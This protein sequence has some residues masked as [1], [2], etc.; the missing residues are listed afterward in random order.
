MTADSSD[1]GTGL[2]D[3]DVPDKPD[4][5]KLPGID[6]G[7]Y[8]YCIDQVRDDPDFETSGVSDK[9]TSVVGVDG[10][11]SVQDNI[12]AAPNSRFGSA[13]RGYRTRLRHN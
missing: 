6:E 5:A 7:R 2:G 4:E 3:L 10:I 12:A 1:L 9:P 13:G 11:G 8:R